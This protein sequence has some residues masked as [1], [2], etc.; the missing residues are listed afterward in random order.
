MASILKVD[1]IGKTTGSTQ[2]T[3]S[4]MAKAWTSDETLE[5]DTAGVWIGDTFNVTSI[6]DETTGQCLVNFTNGFGNTVFASQGTQ[7]VFSLN[8][9]VS[10]K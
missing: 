7:S 1:S 9:I 3:M 5:S 4:G 6:T 8:V 10:T 2:D